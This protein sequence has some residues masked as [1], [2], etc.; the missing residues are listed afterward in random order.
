[1]TGLGDAVVTLRDRRR[2]GYAIYGDP[3]GLPVLSCH[4]ELLCRLD[5][6][7]GAAVARRFSRV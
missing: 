5:A 3:S 6:S 1:M 4:G 2:L 7:S